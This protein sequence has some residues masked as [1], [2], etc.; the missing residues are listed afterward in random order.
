MVDRFHSIK[1]FCGE[2]DAV[3]ER[4]IKVG[5]L[6]KN[7]REI[8]KMEKFTSRITSSKGTTF[9][10]EAAIALEDK[11]D[12]KI[13]E[14]GS[15]YYQKGVI[16]SKRIDPLDFDLATCDTL[17]ECKYRNFY[18]DAIDP[19][20]LDTLMRSIV[21]HKI[22]AE[23]VAGKKFLFVSGKALPEPLKDALKNNNVDFLEILLEL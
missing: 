17:I 16:P 11:F 6:L 20:K 2:K 5:S 7:E 4:I 14:F 22:T 9:E 15:K 3:L 13:T 19:D 21:R 12:M 10:V 23:E 8:E 18:H 1:G